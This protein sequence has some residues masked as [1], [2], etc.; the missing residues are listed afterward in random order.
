MKINCTPFNIY[1]V[2]ITQNNDPL[3]SLGFAFNCFC[4][5]QFELIASLLVGFS[6]PLLSTSLPTRP[7]TH[8]S[9]GPIFLVQYFML[10]L[11]SSVAFYVPKISTL[12]FIAW[13]EAICLNCTAHVTQNVIKMPKVDERNLV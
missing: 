8:T 4:V 1:I 2:F 6:R 3:F 7:H 10:V 12:I 9:V 5:S 11:E 13:I